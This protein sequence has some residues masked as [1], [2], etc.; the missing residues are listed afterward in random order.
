MA[1][2]TTTFTVPKTLWPR[3]CVDCGEA[4]T[5]PGSLCSGCCG[6]DREFVVEDDA[7]DGEDGR[8]NWDCIACGAEV[9][10]SFED[11][12]VFETVQ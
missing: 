3:M 6:H 10:P 8:I 1:L 11:G 2:D 5:G 9:E 12:F 4:L 7:R